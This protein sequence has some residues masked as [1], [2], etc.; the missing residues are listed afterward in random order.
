MAPF[1]S[2]TTTAAHGTKRKIRP[3]VAHSFLCCGRPAPQTKTNNM[4]PRWPKRARGRL[5]TVED[6]DDEE[7]GEGADGANSVLRSRFGPRLEARLSFFAYMTPG[8]ASQH[9]CGPDDAGQSSPTRGSRNPMQDAST[10]TDPTMND[11]ADHGTNMQTFP[12]MHW[13]EPPPTTTPGA[14]IVDAAG[15]V[16]GRA[17]TL[18]PVGY[19]PYPMQTNTSMAVD[20]GITVQVHHHHTV[21][22]VEQP[23][24]ETV[25]GKYW[26]HWAFLVHD[27]FV[28]GWTSWYSEDFSTVYFWNGLTNQS[29]WYPPQHDGSAGAAGTLY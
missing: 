24:E 19:N 18:E 1:R 9:A 21:Y 11:V 28:K 20:S 23:P 2:V 13:M 25:R 26:A 27:D 22:P 15:R 10:Q 29:S 5:K 3:I 16:C 4:A 14:L 7:G 17:D 8:P 12:T 6:E